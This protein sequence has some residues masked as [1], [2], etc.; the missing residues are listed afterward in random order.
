[1]SDLTFAAVSRINRQRCDRW[2]PGFP[3]DGVWLGSDWSNAMAGE[4]G[5]ACN[6][7]KKLRRLE[8]GFAAGGDNAPPDPDT[9]REWLMSKLAKEIG[10]V[11]LYLDLLAQFYGLNLAQCVVGAFNEV[12]QRQGH[13]ERI[14]AS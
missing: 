13:P 7:V 12:S 10:D 8:T 5:E 3:D 11:Y 6:I 1:V 14:E 9:A 4:A 2:H